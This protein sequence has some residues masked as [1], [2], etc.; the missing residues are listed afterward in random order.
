MIDRDLLKHRA[1]FARSLRNH[2][3]E[4]S[5]DGILFP[6]QGVVAKGVYIHDVNGL[7]ERRDEN[8][9]VNEGLNHILDVVLHNDTQIATWY[10]AISSGNVSPQATWT[11]ANYSANATEI[12][13][14]YDEATRVAYNEAAASSQSIT[15]TA[16]KATFTCNTDTTTVWGAALLSV[17]TKGGTTGKLLSAAKFSAARTL[18]DTDTIN[19]GYTITLSST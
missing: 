13:V 5:P 16:N 14:A 15:N 19:I 12:T 9:V 3:Y 7:D 8:L 2:Q 11:A 18:N 10:M 4:V 17:N 1:E 6:Q